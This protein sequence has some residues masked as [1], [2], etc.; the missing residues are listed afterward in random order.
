MAADK[1]NR[2]ASVAC[3]FLFFVPTA[4]ISS[5]RLVLS[6]WFRRIKNSGD[7]TYSAVSLTLWFLFHVRHS[8]S[9]S[10]SASSA[11]LHRGPMTRV[12]SFS[13]LRVMSY[14]NQDFD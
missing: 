1:F 7:E 14:H 2:A 4:Y 5:T 6:M 9:S 11:Y 8:V 13:G 12:M 3:A 10:S